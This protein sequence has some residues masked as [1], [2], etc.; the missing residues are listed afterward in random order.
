MLENSTSIVLQNLLY[1]VYSLH[2]LFISTYSIRE[3]QFSRK[4]VYA[5]TLPYILRFLKHM[6]NRFSYVMGVSH[7]IRKN[8]TVQLCIAFR[9]GGSEKLPTVPHLHRKCS[10]KTFGPGKFF[11]LH[12]VWIF[13]NFISSFFFHDPLLLCST[14]TATQLLRTPR[15]FTTA[16]STSLW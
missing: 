14:P 9:N 11:F 4:N 5:H 10:H 16:F 7:R 1:A 13:S 15:G 3:I 8:K 12:G 2:Q 6:K